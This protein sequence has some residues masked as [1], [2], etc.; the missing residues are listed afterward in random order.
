MGLHG[1]AGPV[2]KHDSLFTLTWNSLLGEGVTLEKR[3]VF[4]VLKKSQMKHDGSTM[5]SVFKL[6][7]WSLNCC[8]SG[9]TPKLDFFGRP[10]QGGGEDIAMKLRFATVQVRGD[11]EFYSDF[12]HIPRWNTALNCCWLC[13]AGSDETKLW[14]AWGPSAGWRSTRKSQA[15]FERELADK[16]FPIPPLIKDTIGL[17]IECFMVDIL[18]AVDQGIPM[19]PMGDEACWV[20]A[21]SYFRHLRS[22]PNKIQ[23]EILTSH[24]TDRSW[25]TRHKRELSI[26]Q[27]ASTPLSRKA[28]RVT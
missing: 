4:T 2:S 3:F 8:L 16:G 15:I 28:L 10:C 6:L 18:H 7:A 11:W 21:H 12:F 19:Q 25:G 24:V 22:A 9:R 13:G 20:K 27:Q 23:N 1:D 17:R 26:T 14:T 5:N